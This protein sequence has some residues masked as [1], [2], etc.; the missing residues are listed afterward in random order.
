MTILQ[1]NLMKKNKHSQK[2]FTLIELMVVIAIAGILIAIGATTFSQATHRA[3]TKGLSDDITN[4]LKRTRIAAMTLGDEVA[5]CVVGN[6]NSLDATTACQPWT[7]LR[8]RQADGNLGLIVFKDND[9]DDTLDDTDNLVTQLAFDDYGKKVGITAITNTGNAI[10]F[11]RK[12]LLDTGGRTITL[13]SNNAHYTGAGYDR[14]I[15]IAA[16]TG[17]VRSELQQ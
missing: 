2:G 12:G 14:Q 13:G 5:V 17:R 4:L 11:T 8:V 15:F 10:R 1:V 9:N 7:D 3:A 16:N 6:I